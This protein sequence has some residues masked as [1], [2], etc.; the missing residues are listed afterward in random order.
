[1]KFVTYSN[2]FIAL[3]AFFHT[4]TTYL[5]FEKKPE[6]DVLIFA[7][8]ATLF[9]YNFIRITKL[10]TIPAEDHSD[11]LLWLGKNLKPVTILSII[12]FLVTLFLFFFLSKWQMMIVLITGFIGLNYNFS[13]GKKQLSIRKIPFAKSFIISAVWTCITLI[14]PLCGHTFYFEGKLFL[15]CLLFVYV[16]MIPFDI[17]DLKYDDSSMK[18][19]PQLFGI[20]GAVVTG[21]ILL[22]TCSCLAFDIFDKKTAILLSISYCITAL[23]LLVSIKKRNEIFYPLVVDGMMIVQGLLVIGDSRFEI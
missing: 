17:R 12:A 2:I 13:F 10:K 14:V 6:V 18:T 5:L 7:F 16:L 4:L 23:V 21:I 1:M 3:A 22:L 9:L 20:T 15:L 19:L 8:S 11:H